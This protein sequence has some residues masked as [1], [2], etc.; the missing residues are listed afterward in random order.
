MEYGKSESHILH[1][2]NRTDKKAEL[3]E[4]QNRFFALAQYLYNHFV[5]VVEDVRSVSD[6]HK[7]L[8]D[9]YRQEKMR[10]G[11]D[12]S[13][14]LTLAESQK[15]GWVQEVKLKRGESILQEMQDT[16][17]QE[18]RSGAFAGT[19]ATDLAEQA[20]PDPAFEEFLDGLIS[21][22]VGIPSVVAARQRLANQ[23]NDSTVN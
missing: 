20:V 13:T 2:D 6:M 12:F 9:M 14:F 18:V 17:D 19:L 22:T 5:H 15:A 16:I 7:A 23:E 1:G 11:L 8:V 4:L 21:P 3:S 10:S